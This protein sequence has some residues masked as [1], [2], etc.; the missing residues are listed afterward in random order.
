MKEEERGKDQQWHDGGVDNE[1]II[2]IGQ[3]LEV[4]S[5]QGTKGQLEYLGRGSR[6]IGS[7]G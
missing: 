1:R 7:D 5:H 2:V 4:G 6:R 3:W